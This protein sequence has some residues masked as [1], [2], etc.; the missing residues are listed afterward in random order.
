M[1][2]KLCL[3]NSY[4]D[5]SSQVAELLLTS[6]VLPKLPKESELDDVAYLQLMSALFTR[7]YFTKCHPRFF[8]ETLK[9]LPS[10]VPAVE[11]TV[12]IT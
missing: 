12:P 5:E 10:P 1:F 8:L 2:G 4:G 6:K 11:K 9:S 7:A 3:E